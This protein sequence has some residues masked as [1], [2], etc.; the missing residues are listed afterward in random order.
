[1]GTGRRLSGMD[2]VDL[3]RTIIRDEEGGNNSVNIVFLKD[4][5]YRRYIGIVNGYHLDAR[6]N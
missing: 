4:L 5:C 2:K 3:G 1:M 6:L